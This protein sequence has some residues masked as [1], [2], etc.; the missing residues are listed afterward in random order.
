[1]ELE[2][3]QGIYVEIE[4]LGIQFQRRVLV[5]FLKKICMH[6]DLLSIPQSGGKMSKRLGEITGCKYQTSS[7]HLNGFPDGNNIGSN[8][9]IMS[10]EKPTVI[11][12]TNINRYEGKPNETKQK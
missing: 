3:P 2:F 8:N 4:S 12:Y 9:S 5:M 10:W 6:L 1:M 11:L 7:W